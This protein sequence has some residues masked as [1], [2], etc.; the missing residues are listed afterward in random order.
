MLDT[1]FE[2][3]KQMDWGTDL[4]AVT[5]I[6]DAAIAAHGKPEA[7]QDLENRLLAALSGSLSRDAQDY[8]CRKLATIGS[9]AA[10]PALSAL[11]LKPENSHM[12]RFALERIPAAEAGQALRDAV[13]KVSSQQQIGIISSLGSRRE[14]AAVATL[15]GALKNNDAAVSRAAAL[16]LGTIGTAESAAALQSALNSASPCVPCIIDGL[17][18][19]AESLLASDKRAEANSIYKSLSQDKQPRLVRLAATRGLL[20]CAGKVS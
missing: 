15:A 2:A 19:C 6:E 7:R 10:V 17:L 8:V 11:L 3:L 9:V 20:A 14:A 12:A 16:A 1:A 13:P 5:P 18:A 4:A